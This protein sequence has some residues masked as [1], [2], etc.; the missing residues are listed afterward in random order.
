MIMAPPWDPPNALP[1]LQLYIYI[2]M[3]GMYVAL[4]GRSP[5]ATAQSRTAGMQPRLL[6]VQRRARSPA[7]TMSCGRR[8]VAECT[9]AVRG[10]SDT[11]R[12]CCRSVSTMESSDRLPTAHLAIDLPPDTNHRSDLSSSRN[13]RTACRASPCH[14]RRALQ[15]GTP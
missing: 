11:R 10:R 12:A 13:Q 8:E 3:H 5:H 6:R 1:E 2:S 9:R 15:A 14:P 7:L 4:A